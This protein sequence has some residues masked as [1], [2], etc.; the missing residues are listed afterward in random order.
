MILPNPCATEA[1]G[2]QVKDLTTFRCLA[3]MELRHEL[4]S[5]SRAWIPL[6]GNVK[7]TFSVDK[8]SYVGIQSF[9]LIVRTWRVVTLH[10]AQANKRL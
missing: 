6:D 9:L 2:D 7:R 5:G 8:P 4:P 1:P 3:D 10:T